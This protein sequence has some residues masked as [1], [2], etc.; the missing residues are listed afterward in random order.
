MR[1]FFR[2]AF[3]G[4]PEAV[5]HTWDHIISP[6]VQDAFSQCGALRFS[7]MDVRE[8][9]RRIVPIELGSN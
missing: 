8:V 7:P 4:P 9:V 3:V 2:N 1:G 6:L 5:A